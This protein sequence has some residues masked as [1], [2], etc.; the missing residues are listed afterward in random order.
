MGTR[1]VT[2]LPKR[3]TSFIPVIPKK[4]GRVYNMSHRVFGLWQENVSL[5]GTLPCKQHLGRDAYFIFF[6][7]PTRLNRM[8]PSNFEKHQ[9]DGH[10]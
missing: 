4:V 7:V 5:D 1:F 10:N 6:G 8:A 2:G 9:N 3:N